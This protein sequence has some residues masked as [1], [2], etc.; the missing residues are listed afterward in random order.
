MVTMSGSSQLE[1]DST[2]AMPVPMKKWSWFR[3]LW[4]CA[5]GIA[6]VISV[7]AAFRGGY[8]GGDYNIH[9]TRIREGR[10]F[11][12]SMA[13]PPLYIFIGHWLF[14]L[15]GRNNGFVITLSI[16]Q[17]A[18]NLLAMWWFFLYTERRFKSGIVHLAFVFFL[19]FL[20][21][22][23]IHAVSQG[24]DWLTIPVFVLVLFVF[25]KFL[26]EE[27]S[28][29]RNALWLGLAMA[30]GIW[31][32]YS[33]MALLPAVFVMFVVLW[34]KHAWSLG[35]FI[36]ICALSLLLP[37]ALV[38]Y[39]HW[40]SGKVKDA[41][42]HKIWIPKGGLAGQ[43]DM[44]YKDLFSVKAADLQLFKA[45]E[46]YKRDP[47]LPGYVVHYG[48]KV[49]HMHGYLALSHMFTFTD[50][51]NLFQDLPGEPGIDRFLIP[52]FKTR[53]PWKTPV[54]VA[55]MSLGTIWTTLALIGTPWI[56][57][58][59]VYHLFRNKLEREDV[60]ALLGTAYFLLM[61]LP[62]PFVVYGCFNGYWTSRL[63]LPPLLFFY[64]AAFLLLDRKIV[65]K[66]GKAPFVVLA[67]A[68][69]QSGIE[70][71]VLT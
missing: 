22:R 71:V 15:I 34:W 29:P 4:A 5:L 16:L 36:L 62:I 59:A 55:S 41:M 38:V 50:T 9:L 17:A 43:P 19:T 3:I 20:P 60:T 35:R 57:C 1:C 48:Y 69:I 28:L 58:G 26:S 18:I 2:E 12:F 13:D 33:F 70:M 7:R 68:I 66:W 14:R 51:W 65:P 21:V 37:S 67:L 64:W 54:M 53:R 40:E 8:V 30:V 11:D 32:K 6:F 49:A 23:V 44:G 10:F 25:D 47:S 56:F 52:D 27:T 46:M 45:P 63:I 39:S 61:F 42:A 31:S 24:T